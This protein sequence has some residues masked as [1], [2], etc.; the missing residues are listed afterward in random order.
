MAAEKMKIA[1]LVPHYLCC[2]GNRIVFEHVNR[3]AEKGHE[4][5]LARLADTYSANWFKLNERVRL[6]RF[7]DLKKGI[8]DIDCIVAT[9]HL[10]VRDLLDLPETVAKFYF[11]QS[12]ERKFYDK[13]SL[14]FFECAETYRLP[15]IHY[16]TE[17]KWIRQ[18]LIGEFGHQPAYIP[19]KINF[20][21]F[22]PDP[23]IK[24]DK[25]AVLIEGNAN[26]FYK[27]VEQALGAISH[28]DC[29]KWLLTNSS[30][31]MLPAYTKGFDRVW[32][33]PDQQTVRQVISSADI[34]IK[35][36]YFEGSPLPHMEAMACKTALITTDIPGTRE[37][38]IDRENCLMVP[39]GDS[40]AIRSAADELIADRGLRSKLI[41]QAFIFAQTN[42][43]WADSIDK[44][45]NMFRQLKPKP[46]SLSVKE[47]DDDIGLQYNLF[48]SYC[49]DDENPV[50]K[51]AKK[52]TNLLFFR[53]RVKKTV[54]KILP[55][56]VIEKMLILL[57]K[58]GRK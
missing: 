49:I 21:D 25:T 24:H 23:V 38:C 32:S 12:D 27:G 39:V 11:V 50:I 35:P 46:V 45:E 33:L 37:Y 22:F 19:N 42:Y 20:E 57:Q 48:L 53:E 31:E 26:H 4:L 3:L 47:F 17:A 41:D 2:G 43:Q 15:N 8:A 34:L 54:K 5:Y 51:K 16:F 55:R 52:I 1:Y 18:M 7:S 58:Y 29:E 44:L 28:I 9:Y 13:P 40:A 36:S 30:Q 10:T 6:V 14:G 56:P